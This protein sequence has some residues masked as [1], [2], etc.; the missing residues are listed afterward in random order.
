VTRKTDDQ[1]GWLRRTRAASNQLVERLV[2]R[3]NALVQR[4]TRLV[5]G[6]DLGWEFLHRF[7]ARNG[8]VLVGHLAYRMFVW[9]A[10]LMF[11]LAAGLGF[12]ASTF[13]IVGYATEFG[14]SAETAQD[15]VEQAEQSRITALAI[16]IPAL[17]FASWSLIHGTH[18]AYSQAWGIDIKSR[19]GVV[20]QAAIVTFAVLAIGVLVAI[21]S[22]VQRQGPILAAVGWVG[23]FALTTVSLW[24]ISRLMPRGTDRWRDLLPGP[25]FGALGMSLLHVFGSVY[26]PARIQSASV[27]YG[28]IGVAL[29]VL[30]YVFLIAYLLI[31]TPFI[32]SVWVDREEILAGRPWVDLR[33]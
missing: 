29:A 13:D 12:S 8:T 9:L 28:A 3:I 20:G 21:I 32:N 23:A 27:L 11:V 5:P 24:L 14:V 15:A 16:G 30:F 4:A 25:L 26:L 2:A 18:Y 6:L 22:A 1:P 17:I 10:P 7:R 19:K 33:R 31:L